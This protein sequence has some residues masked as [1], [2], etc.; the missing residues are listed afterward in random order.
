M[1]EYLPSDSVTSS[2]WNSHPAEKH[3]RERKFEGP[4]FTAS[5]VQLA[6]GQYFFCNR[7]QVVRELVNDDKNIDMSIRC[8]VVR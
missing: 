2:G 3:S 1:T 6:E 7:F 5:R 4:A 8:R